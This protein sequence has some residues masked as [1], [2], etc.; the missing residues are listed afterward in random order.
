MADE[1]GKNLVHAAVEI[2]VDPNCTSAFM[3]ISA[4]ENGGLDITMQRARAAVDEK[5]ISHGIIEEAI[6]DAVENKR[7]GENICI[8]RW[9]PPIDG[10]DGTIKYNFSKDNNIAPVQNS[11]GD[12]DF[13]NLGL[14]REIRAGTVIASITFPTEG[15]PGKD[16]T[17]KPVPQKKG[18]A[19]KYTVGKGTV[20]TGGDTEIIAA[21]D[22]NLEYEQGAFVVNEELI[23]KEDVDV[24]SGNIEF[25][26]SVSVRGNV[27]EGFRIVSKKNITVRGSV[28]G[29]EIIAD[30]NIT[31]GTGA[32]NSTIKA[33]GAIKLGFCEN[34][35]VT[36]G[37]DI[38][39]ASFIGGEVFC[40]G[41]INATGKGVMVGGKYTALENISAGTIGSE[42][43]S[44][45]LITLGNNAVLSEERDNLNRLIAE[46]EDK[47][48]QLG[49]VL[50]TL[51]EFAKKAKL[52]PE[53]EQMK[54]EAVR[55]RIKMQMEVKKHNQ[56]IA[57]IEQ[58][59]LVN[60]TL[61]VSVRKSMYPGVT[62]RINDCVLPVNTET[63][64]S[65]ATIEHG[66][67]VF[68][69]L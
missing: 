53:R 1:F 29:A 46:L 49:K 59:L 32:V 64:Y 25:L 54:A 6:R 44:R 62:L 34:C 4:P 15:T 58:C 2:S 50:D 65:R 11:K 45:T 9:T 27:C 39:C 35:K 19:A 10:V 43:Y 12:V 31:V 68:K 63:S 5:M 18:V 37:K 33:A 28:N 61:T 7:Y 21:V 38:E 8:A 23:I 47:I 66:E 20:L 22:G 42:N 13:K 14:V 60:Q 56:R 30:G 55:S 3:S 41:S 17:G 24:S 51:A 16:I 36:S 26:G 69:P 40:G 52:P 57:Q 48:D 67:I